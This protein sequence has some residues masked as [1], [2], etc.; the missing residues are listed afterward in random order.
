MCCISS[1]CEVTA[2]NPYSGYSASITVAD[3]GAEIERGFGVSVDGLG[4]GQFLWL[5]R[6]PL[7][8]SRSKPLPKDSCQRRRHV[9]LL[10]V[11]QHPG[12]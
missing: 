11:G 3:L 6:A 9:C 2:S 7:T 12:R 4:K 10:T 8:W 5:E 1:T